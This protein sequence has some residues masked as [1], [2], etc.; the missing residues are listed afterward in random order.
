MSADR[1][2]QARELVK[3]L[4]EIQPDSVTWESADKWTQDL[5]SLVEQGTAAIAPL[6][7][8][9]NSGADVRFDTGKTNLLSEPSLR[10]AFIEVLFNVPA[11]ENV[12]LQGRLLRNTTDPA[13]VALLARQLEAQEP[14][15]YHDLIVYQA[16]VALDQASHGQWPGRDTKPLLKMLKDTP[17]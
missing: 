2:V 4:S 6:D 1:S 15:K 9:F 8:F 17:R 16:Q 5:E 12:E 10:M 14:G 11:P 13:E 3:R 7:D